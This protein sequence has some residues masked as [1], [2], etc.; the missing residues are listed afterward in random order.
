MEKIHE[1]KHYVKVTFVCNECGRKMNDLTLCPL[2]HLLRTRAAR[3]R[4]E[5]CV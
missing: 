2:F 5:A 3:H 1:R 4:T